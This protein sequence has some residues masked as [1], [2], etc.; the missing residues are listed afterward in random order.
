MIIILI[1]NLSFKPSKEA[2]NFST[3]NVF[4]V[5]PEW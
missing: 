5:S 3:Q 1:L 4:P 2:E